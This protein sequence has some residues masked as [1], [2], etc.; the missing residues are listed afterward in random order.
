MHDG[1]F[2]WVMA[3]VWLLLF[4]CAGLFLSLLPHGM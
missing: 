1:Q 4:L 2:V 3:L